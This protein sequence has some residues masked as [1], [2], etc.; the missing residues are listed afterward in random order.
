M[1]N[2]FPLVLYFML[3]FLPPSVRNRQ[4]SLFKVYM[5]LKLWDYNSVVDA[6]HLRLPSLLLTYSD[7]LY[8]DV[9]LSLS[10]VTCSFLFSFA[11]YE[12][13]GPGIRFELQL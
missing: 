13:P 3:S 11:A 4:F 12:V 5:D 6:M 8:F 10:G 7:T 1:Y 9:F 2:F